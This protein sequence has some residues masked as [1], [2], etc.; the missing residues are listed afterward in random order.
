MLRSRF[1][2]SLL[3]VAL[4][5]SQFSAR[6]DLASSFKTPAAEAQPW[7]FW[8]WINGNI[9][10]EGITADLEAMHR[11]G[12]GGVLIM[13]VANPKS[14]APEG[15]V[16]FASPQWME[17]FAHAVSE[18]KRLGMKLN[19]NNDAGWCGSGGPWV[20]PE[21]SM[22]TIVST[23]A[24][25]N[26]PGPV[27]VTLPQPE[28]VAG[29][30]GDIA[31]FAVRQISGAA[32]AGPAA[33][34]IHDAPTS[35]GEVTWQAPAG[36]WKIMR[37]GYTSTGKV[38]KPAPKSGEGLEV[39]KFDAAAMDAHYKEFIGKLAEQN[40]AAV[41]SAFVSTHIDSWEVGGQTWTGRMAEE[42]RKRRG[43]DITPYLPVLAGEETTAT[44]I[45]VRFMRDFTLTCSELNDENYAGE[46]RRQ[47]NADKLELSIEAYGQGGFLNPLTYGAE[48]NTPVSEF[49]ISRWDAWHLL[50]PRLM[51]SVSHVYGRPITA[52]ES[53][54]SSAGNDP[55]TE[56]P[57]SV[58]STGDWA[59]C[60]GVNRIIFH[61]AVHDPWTTGPQ[62][63]PGMSFAGYGWHVDRK[64][65][66]YEQGSAFM[67][68]LARCQT[69]LQS[70]RFVADVAR[71]VTDGEMRGNTAGMHQI[72]DQYEELPAGYNYD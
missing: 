15:P 49:W 16:K 9:S 58:K 67:Q 70:G 5:G 47:A 24:T 37:I 31:V 62:L 10:R 68:Y 64:Q 8:F 2:R 63:L 69:V 55:F 53:F 18:A 61:R 71:V 46:L 59:M 19:M 12:I 56:Y 22:K 42:F 28:A 33:I 43:Y 7:S 25:V 54:T 23:E 6:A 65:T 29:L 27:T 60:E 66:W 40:R 44:D 21:Q 26:G 50:S 11:V 52:A 17:L 30:Y 32:S 3:I 48:A 39:D 57:F 41:G 35:A 72:P 51:A 36:A 45:K 14:M 13:E 20:K 34:Q 1:V 38:N 4:A